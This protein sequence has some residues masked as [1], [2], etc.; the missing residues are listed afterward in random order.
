[1]AVGSVCSVGAGDCAMLGRM[2]DL[3]SLLQS[4]LEHRADLFQQ[5][6][7][8]DTDCY[9]L[10]H[11]SNE[12]CPGL[13]VDRYGPQLLMQTFHQPLT[14]AEREAVVQ[15]MQMHFDPAEIVYNDRSTPHSRRADARR[16]TGPRWT[17]RELGVR[18]WVQGKHAGQDPWLFLD[19]RVGR[20][21]VQAQAAGKSVLNL[22]AY[23][24]GVGLCAALAGAR[25]VW[26]IDFANQALDVGRQN[27][28]LNGLGETQMRLIQSD[29]FPA[30]RQLAGLP[31]KQRRQKGRAPRPFL[32]LESR[33]FDLVVLDP[34]RWAKSPFGTVDLI[35][36]YPSVFKPALLATASGGQ[37]LCSNNVAQVELQDWLEMLQRAARKVGRPVRDWE[38]LVP[39]ADFPSRDGIHPLKLALLQ[40]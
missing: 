5:L 40:V 12:G 6:Q 32:K 8:E 34:P 20:R 14:P 30:V 28:E 15:I 4:A 11:G 35:R 10:F 23:T 39:E 2:T 24:C 37:L 7:A 3:S 33:P 36:D 31:V 1:M 13:T 29:F 18:Y 26:N 22:F 17:A 27:A 25:E 21:W 16:Q 9:R 38:V 19:L